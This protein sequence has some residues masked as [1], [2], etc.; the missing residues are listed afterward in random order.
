MPSI[1]K[2]KTVNL[3]HYTSI[4][5]AVLLTCFQSAS[6]GDV[7]DFESLQQ[8]M[9][10]INRNATNSS[11]SPTDTAQYIKQDGNV[12]VIQF[13]GNYDQESANGDF[14]V[15]A[16][17]D[18]AQAFYQQHGDDY[19][20]LSILTDFEFATGDAL[21]F[22]HSTQNKVSGIGLP[23]FDNTAIYGS[24][25]RLQGM[26]DM[27]AA[28]R[29]Q[30]DSQA[31]DFVNPQT[32]YGFAP[33][34]S[35]EIM[36]NWM[37]GVDIQN[38][39]G[40]LNQALRGHA[41][42]HWSFLTDSKASVMGGAQWLS[43][44]E[45][46]H[47]ATLLNQTYHDWDLYLAGLLDADSTANIEVI[48]DPSA[49]NTLFP[50][51]NF[52]AHGPRHA[53]SIQQLID[54]YGP[55][56]PAS[57]SSQRQF[58]VGFIYLVRDQEHI[59]TEVVSQI[60]ALQQH[61]SNYFHLITRQQASLTTHLSNKQTAGIGQIS[62][63]INP[64][65]QTQ[66]FDAQLA[67]DWLIS[68]QHEDGSWQ[69]KNS[70]QV[71]DTALSTRLIR[72]LRPQ[73]SAWLRGR[74]WL[75]NHQYRSNDERLWALNSG[76]L[77]LGTARAIGGYIQ[78]TQNQDGGWGLD[79]QY[80]S[81]ALDTALVLNTAN[82][83]SGLDL[84]QQQLSDGLLY[85]SST[86]SEQ[87][88][89][90][91]QHNGASSLLSS[92]QVYRT[93]NQPPHSDDSGTLPSSA[94]LLSYLL[95]QQAADGSFGSA[96]DTAMAVESLVSTTSNEEEVT[97]AVNQATAQAI[98]QLSISQD[99]EGHW[100]HSIYATAL[101]S[102]LLSE[103]Q[104]INLSLD[105]IQFS[106][107]RI[108]PGDQFVLSMNIRNSGGQSSQ[109]VLLSLL[110]N[111]ESANEVAPA[112][113]IPPLMPGQRF[114]V[115]FHL[116]STQIDLSKS[117][118][119]VIDLANTQQELSR[120]DNRK[121]IEF[122][123]QTA[124][125]G[126]DFSI[127]SS[128][129]TLSPD[130]I[131]QLPEDVTINAFISNLGT[132]N[133]GPSIAAIYAIQEAGAPIL[134][135]RETIS[136]DAGQR[137]QLSTQHSFVDRNIIA[138]QF[139]V[140]EQNRV[141]ENNEDNN[142]FTL[143]IAYED[144]LDFTAETLTLNASDLSIGN[145]YPINFQIAN[146][147][148]IDAQ[149][150]TVNLYV[151]H[152]Q[153]E[154]NIF[155]GLFDIT[156][157]QGI[158]HSTDWRPTATG[159]HTLTLRVDDTEQ[160]AESEEANNELS[161][162]AIV[163]EATLPNL[164]LIPGISSTP[165][166]LL[167]GQEALFSVIV[168]ND[169]ANISSSVDVT[170][171]QGD[172][173]SSPALASAQITEG[174][175]SGQQRVVDIPYTPTGSGEQFFAAKVDA[176]QRIS[177]LDEIDNTTLNNLQV[178]GLA[179]LQITPSAIN[180]NPSNPNA[181][182]DV[183]INIQFTNSGQ[184]TT[185]A[186]SVV[187]TLLQDGNRFLEQRFSID[188][189]IAAGDNGTLN[190]QLL[191][192]AG[193]DELSLK[194]IL[195]SDQAIAESD[196]S[197]NQAQLSISTQSGPIHVTEQYLSP[198]GDE[199]KDNTTISF[200]VSEVA[201][202]RLLIKGVDDE[203]VKRYE[204]IP[205]GQQGSVIWD[206]RN[207]QGRI[208]LDGTYSVQLLRGNSLIATRNIVVDTDRTALA[209]SI[210]TPRQQMIPLSCDIGRPISSSVSRFSSRVSESGE[211]LYFVNPTRQSDDQ[212]LP[213]IY[214]VNTQSQEVTSIID[215]HW[216]LTLTAQRGTQQVINNAYPL[217][218]HR[219]LFEAN[220]SQSPPTGVCN[221][222][223]ASL[224]T[225]NLAGQ[226]RQLN[227]ESSFL[228]QVIDR[229][230]DQHILVYD[231]ETLRPISLGG[232]FYLVSLDGINPAKQLTKPFTTSN[233]NQ[234]LYY[235][236]SGRH[237]SVFT[238]QSDLNAAADPVEN[239][240]L[241]LL[242]L[243]TEGSAQLIDDIALNRIALSNQ[244][245][246]ALLH[247]DK[248]ISITDLNSPDAERIY[249]DISHFNSINI[250]MQWR[251]SFNH[252]MVFDRNGSQW[253][254][255]NQ[256]GQLIESHHV[257]L[258]PLEQLQAQFRT[259]LGGFP[260]CD[261][262]PT[263]DW[264]AR[265]RLRVNP[266]GASRFSLSGHAFLQ[267]FITFSPSG[268]EAWWQITAI[269]EDKDSNGEV[270]EPKHINRVAYYHNFNTN[271]TH[272][273]G[274]IPTA[275]NDQDWDGEEQIPLIDIDRTINIPITQSHQGP[276]EWLLPGRNLVNRNGHFIQIR[277]HPGQTAYG[278]L[279]SE[280]NTIASSFQLNSI[281]Y[282]LP[283]NPNVTT[284]QVIVGAHS[285][286]ENA[287][288]N[289]RSGLWSLRSLDNLIAQV[290]Y[291][292]DGDLLNIQATATDKNFSHY[293][294]D[295][296]HLDQQ[297][298]GEPNIYRPIIAFADTEANAETISFWSPPQAGRYRIRLTVYDRAGNQAS[299]SADVFWS[300]NPDLT[301][302]DGKPNYI[303]PNAD[304][305]NDHFVISYRAQRSL[306]L[307]VQIYDSSD[308][309]VRSIRQD[310][311]NPTGNLEQVLWDGRDQSGALV[312]DG[313]YSVRVNGHSLGVVV[314]QHAPQISDID[315]HIS[316][317]S[318]N[319]VH[320]QPIWFVNEASPA[321]STLEVF[322]GEPGQ[323]LLLDS[324][325]LRSSDSTENP[326]H[327]RTNFDSFPLEILAHNPLRL[328]IEDEAGN[329]TS[330]IGQYEP[331]V[332]LLGSTHQGLENPSPNNAFGL[333]ETLFITDR[334]R[335]FDRPNSPQTGLYFT[336]T[337]GSTLA[338]IRLEF[339]ESTGDGPWLPLPIIEDARSEPEAG[340]WS[341]LYPDND[342]R[343][344]LS[345]A[346]ILW[347]MQNYPELSDYR[348][349][350]VLSDNDGHE[351][352]SNTVLFNQQFEINTIA[353]RPNTPWADMLLNEAQANLSPPLDT[354]QR[355]WFSGTSYEGISASN[356]LLSISSFDDPR[357]TQAIQ[358]TPSAVAEE[359][360]G[361]EIRFVAIFDA[362]LV[363]PFLYQINANADTVSV[364]GQASTVML[365]LSLP[366]VCGPRLNLSIS[367]QLASECDVPISPHIIVDTEILMGDVQSLVYSLANPITGENQ[368]I[369]SDTTVSSVN[370]KLLDVS[371]LNLGSYQLTVTAQL[372]DNTEVSAS[373][374]FLV[375]DPAPSADIHYPA[376]GDTI[377]ANFIDSIPAQLSFEVEASLPQE[378]GL[379]HRVGVH[380]LNSAIAI[381]GDNLEAFVGHR[382]PQIGPAESCDPL[383][384][385]GQ[386]N[387]RFLPES[388]HSPTLFNRTVERR[389]ASFTAQQAA[390]AVVV[391]SNWNGQLSCSINS[392]NLD[393][394]I[395]IVSS[396]GSDQV[397]SPNNDGVLDRF[398]IDLSVN[399]VVR[400][401]ITIYPASQTPGQAI[402]IAGP[403]LAQPI[404]ALE[405]NGEY[406]FE[407]DGSSE[408]GTVA[409]GLYLVVVSLQD[410]CGFETDI[411]MPAEVDTTPPDVSISNPAD[412]SA[413][414]HIVEVFGSATDPNFSEY[415]LSFQLVN[416]ESSSRIEVANNTV[417]NTLLG[418]WN[419]SGISEAVDLILD[420]SDSAGN[421]SSTRVRLL[422]SPGNSL[423]SD[424]AITPD[425]FSPDVNNVRDFLNIAVTT[426]TDVLLTLEIINP[427]GQ[428]IHLLSAQHSIDVGTHNYQWDGRNA[429]G[430][431][432]IDGHYLI[433]ASAQSGASL[434][435]QSL[436]FQL[437]NSAPDIQLIYP[438]T[439]I[440][441]A[442]RVLSL[443]INDASPTSLNAELST[444][445]RI[446]QRVTVNA[447][448][449]QQEH[450]INLVEL[451]ELSEG[452]YELT[453]Q[454][455]DEAG[456]QTQS[457]STFL[458]DA[459]LPVSQLL[460]P[461]NDQFWASQQTPLVIN[462]TISDQ[463]LSTYRI[464]YRPLQGAW[465]PIHSAVVDINNQQ[466]AIEF[467][468]HAT[469]R[470]LND[471]D[472]E[473][474]LL[475]IDKAGNE[476]RSS[477]VIHI[478]NTAPNIN[479][480]N[481]DENARVAPGQTLEGSVHDLNL[482][483]YVVSLRPVTTNSNQPWSDFFSGSTNHSGILASIPNITG[484]TSNSAFDIRVRAT[485]QAANTQEIVR[486]IVLD[487]QAPEAPENLAF[488]QSGSGQIQ[489]NW[490]AVNAPDLAAY[491]MTRNGQDFGEPTPQNQINFTQL[492]DGTHQFQ[493][494]AFDHSGN[495][496]PL[497]NSVTVTIDTQAPVALIHAPSTQTLVSGVLDINASVYGDDDLANYH[498]SIINSNIVEQLRQSSI[499]VQSEVIANLNSRE[500]PDGAYTLTL[501]A[502]DRAENTADDFVVIN[503]DNTAPAA[504]ELMSANAVNQQVQLSWSSNTE[505]DL[506]GY[507]VYRNGR[508]VSSPFGAANPASIAIDENQYLD[509]NVPDGQHEYQVRAVD[510]AGNL[511][512]ASN[513]LTV[514]IDQKAPTVTWRSPLDQ[515]EFDFELTLE[516][517]S[518]DEDIE[519]VEFSYREHGTTLWNPLGTAEEQ[520]YRSRLDPTL[521]TF[522]RYELR[523]LA[524]DLSG[525]IDNDP[526][527]ISV[528]HRDLTPPSAVTQLTAQVIEDQIRLE[529]V[530]PTD[531]DLLGFFIERNDG[532]G[533]FRLNA[534]AQHESTYL[535]SALADGAYSYQII[536]VD[537]EQNESTPQSIPALVFTPELLGVP[538]ISVNRDIDVELRSPHP[539]LATLRVIPEGTQ[540]TH[541]LAAEQNVVFEA[542]NLS[543]GENRLELQVQYGENHLSKISVQSIQQVA[544][545]SI[546]NGLMADLRNNSVQLSW[547]ANPED[548]I[549]G[550]RLFQASQAVLPT[551]ETAIQSAIANIN[552]DQAVLSFDANLSSFWP[553]SANQ[554]QG[555][556]AAIIFE[557]AEPILLNQVTLTWG[558]F[559][560]LFPPR[561]FRIQA[562]NQDRWFDIAKQE[563][564][565]GFSDAVTFSS[566]PI[567]NRLRLIIEG[568]AP[569]R[570]EVH[571]SE[572]SVLSTPL[573]TDTTHQLQL[574]RNRYQFQLSAVNSF[575]LQ[576]LRTE[577]LSV[578]VGDF[579]SPQTVE[580]V[581]HNEGHDAVLNWTPNLASDFESYRIYRNGALLLSIQDQNIT[582]YRDITLSN[583]VYSYQMSVTD[584]SGNESPRSNEVVLEINESLPQ[585]PTELSLSALP[586]L[587]AFDLSWNASL[588]E[589]IS[590][591]RVGRSTHAEGPFLP[592]Q[593]VNALAYRD[594]SITPEIHYY[595]VVQS[596]DTQGNL[597]PPSNVVN[598]FL[599]DQQAPGTPRI[600]SPVSDGENLSTDKRFI[601]ITGTAEPG[602]LIE[603]THNSELSQTT[604]TSLE[605]QLFQR[606]Y[607]GFVHGQALFSPDG[608]WLVEDNFPN[609]RLINLNN[610]T[611][612]SLESSFAYGHWSEDSQ[613]FYYRND[614]FRTVHQI[615]VRSQEDH[616][617]LSQ[618]S[619]FAFA[620][621]PDQQSILIAGERLI[622][623]AIESGL[624][625]QHLSSGEISDQLLGFSIFDIASNS[626]SWS[627]DSSHF[628][629]VAQGNGAQR[630]LHEIGQSTQ[631]L[632]HNAS[633]EAARWSND[634]KALIYSGFDEEFNQQIFHYER[635]QQINTA[636][637]S[638]VAS[639]HSPVW[640]HDQQSVLW[641]EDHSTLAQYTLL[642]Q[643]IEFISNEDLFFDR[644]QRLANGHIRTAGN[645]SIFDVVTAGQFTFEFLSL[646]SGRN[647]FSTRAIDSAGNGS[648]PSLPIEIDFQPSGETDLSWRLEDSFAVPSTLFVEEAIAIT[649]SALSSDYRG[650]HF[651]AHFTIVNEDRGVIIAPQN[652]RFEITPNQEGS[653]R[654]V[655]IVAPS[656][657][658]RYQLI[659]QLDP[660]N[661]I[662]EVDESNN[663]FQQTIIVL[664]N[665]PP[666]ID[667]QV[668]AQRALAG[669]EIDLRIAL[670]NPGQNFLGR[671]QL[672]VFDRTNQVVATL[673][674]RETGPIAQ[675][676]TVNFDTQWNTVGLFASDYS[677]TAQLLDRHGT[678]VSTDNIDIELIDIQSFALRLDIG[679]GQYEQNQLH[680]LF[681]SVEYLSGQTPLA[682][683]VLEYRITDTENN[684]F[685]QRSAQLGL[686]LPGSMN[687]HQI[688]WMAIGIPQGQYVLEL[689][690]RHQGQTLAS[691]SQFITVVSEPDQ[692]RVI[693]SLEVNSGIQIH[694]AN[695]ELHWQL[696]NVGNVADTGL[697]RISLLN[698]VNTEATVYQEVISL[699]PG[700]SVNNPYQL[701]TT[702][703]ALGSHTL[704][705][706]W[707]SEL[708][709]EQLVDNQAFELID[710]TPPLIEV[711]SP[712]NISPANTL[713][714]LHVQD[715]LSAVSTVELL[716]SDGQGNQRTFT[717]NGPD[718]EQ[719]YTTFSQL[720]EG[721]YQFHA[722]A[723][724]S[725]GNIALAMGSFVVDTTAPIITISG[726]ESSQ[727]SSMPLTPVI[728]VEDIH[729]ESVSI[730][731]NN[732]PYSSGTEIT[733]QGIYQ[734]EVIAVDFAGNRSEHSIEFTINSAQ[735]PPG[736]VN[737]QLRGIGEAIIPR[738]YLI[739]S[740]I[741]N[742]GAVALNN[743]NIRYRVSDTSNNLIAE[744]IQSLSLTVGDTRNEFIW[745]N[746]ELLNIETYQLSAEVQLN[747]GNWLIVSNLTINTQADDF[748]F[749]E[750]SLETEIRASG[751][752]ESTAIPLS[753]DKRQTR[754]L[755]IVNKP[756]PAHSQPYPASGLK[757]QADEIVGSTH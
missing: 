615:D 482:Q 598:G 701:D 66:T 415:Q 570:G 381:D 460:Q 207:E 528:L 412:G 427:Q 649:L 303:S 565:Q 7:I 434:Q 272:I 202:Y 167:S 509:E 262:N 338:S 663:R 248:R 189:P 214:A 633:T 345:H 260:D 493:V 41:D 51:L 661:I 71:R 745:L 269:N 695:T 298:N 410:D 713:F 73:S 57:T 237:F 344:W 719:R 132:E 313:H 245:L 692:R 433:L 83:S 653:V 420:A 286:G 288:S 226:A 209:N 173:A 32:G 305:V 383:I 93:F 380:T 362:S 1:Q 603:L 497:S 60:N 175:S 382:F 352:Y 82:L 219:L 445:N 595:Y 153:I 559:F 107:E 104:L 667:I 756:S 230:D 697:I 256:Q 613:T 54:L 348:I 526:P 655:T 236:G 21:A 152:N 738:P 294:L 666:Q 356:L 602:T 115:E 577:P 232:N 370:S 322:L 688:G 335:S 224:W 642:N 439:P 578:A 644:L 55:R 741:N 165:A 69:D 28:T 549:A 136:V 86:L 718:D 512:T 708:G 432:V 634:S 18:I 33:V 590:A 157:G 103:R 181:G 252:L 109:S 159:Q 518:D 3:T 378:P 553:V 164:R 98:S 308:L 357:F 169:G 672:Q 79:Q 75:Q 443:S 588:S 102:R 436:S 419:V 70:T 47:R 179:D 514:N 524:T 293:R 566:A 9:K 315:L 576:S 735:T 739:N 616:V 668:E 490:T 171:F 705:L 496:S 239:A 418:R 748:I 413:I 728:Q 486:T 517:A 673:I 651:E 720:V 522:G 753:I 619:V 550:Y 228:T 681:S 372:A 746:T 126:I 363:C 38:A 687:Q 200:F 4:I 197:N 50:T 361:N 36:H 64:S 117:V 742:T 474:A 227:F 457:L 49:P 374:R 540:F 343:F 724:D 537:Q 712:S 632:H 301:A 498:L 223:C 744:H 225:T 134:L 247:D 645:G 716:L 426:A 297:N 234:H 185:A 133:S 519:R 404:S 287:C 431:T 310:V 740:V 26:I 337:L 538:L 484:S 35:H 542:V 350:L 120:A 349:R 532:E 703:L 367:P 711:Q 160:Y 95:D 384:A 186:F 707:D 690:L 626:L 96:S 319:P 620:I 568:E 346:V 264:H 333:Q 453:I 548:N 552:N 150:L 386:N 749:F 204:D 680:Q 543:P 736:S 254:L 561:A 235:I 589:N 585:A 371:T 20:F 656:E 397:F 654:E 80:L 137:T 401:D 261:D 365:P 389:A 689:N 184:Q 218:N 700:E 253:N 22:F 216:L 726:V 531:E 593:E 366:V 709:D 425:N 143:P 499:P 99:I 399:E 217:G 16:R 623:G 91:L 411:R 694:G 127:R 665:E 407:W 641:I 300:E 221:D 358:I 717:L 271:Q 574:P 659:A 491:Q 148:T 10:G 259:S 78:S 11:N 289:N 500:F 306:Q 485:D 539:G 737:G 605:A 678:V 138:L 624:W 471:G 391:S 176:E 622:D 56:L 222:R 521:L 706:Y 15:Q 504:P 604:T 231:S 139:V 23:I 647:R 396:S 241:Y 609:S 163:D 353:H 111:T 563:S 639:K 166:P 520:P 479:I 757:H 387:C 456:N 487:N 583:G 621:S 283:A 658:G 340:N 52:E 715:L 400:M 268:K 714:K 442:D 180:L 110:D 421:R 625:V 61:V 279:H 441:S 77:N 177:E 151:R 468:W 451:A 428:L 685:Y 693:G 729:I 170:L 394:G 332:F 636:L 611:R 296:T 188:T 755:N 722:S 27:A 5:F 388:F 657:P 472:Y 201:E 360:L 85:L 156:A 731:L 299:D 650:D 402:Q 135:A 212:A 12:A 199:L 408:L 147:G 187:L 429:S 34:F 317:S 59:N 686:L 190:T 203:V 569:A 607:N 395:D 424:M 674:N 158:N 547:Q 295:W 385:S 750:D 473:I 19:D 398:S 327:R 17:I 601:T 675:A 304:Q 364:D 246:L 312:P 480:T 291:R 599:E 53:I 617:L 162:T 704:F 144:T 119:G 68:Q 733:E 314:D 478:D 76:V 334:T 39:D 546:P 210:A 630:Y 351:Y 274:V 489:L 267:D 533:F 62:T 67:V 192:P 281:E 368:V 42:D 581:A 513:A 330:T 646:Q 551:T 81:S 483:S 640:S 263:L 534:Q 290:S 373:Q 311:I 747:D 379:S 727:V 508:L 530:A 475:S 465:L 84:S 699:A 435:E 614:D 430:T 130:N 13:E 285:D 562:W 754:L 403:A 554:I 516:V 118:V 505:N 292:L 682:E 507:L 591:Y 476:H 734:L 467:V 481:P 154:S 627:P 406:S 347:Q 417:Q 129:I 606:D 140:D 87:S 74:D 506:A 94:Q 743:S 198:N 155:T 229:V 211:Y 710:A 172:P 145:N 660:S 37:S 462:G 92:L 280:L 238:N 510:L 751:E 503:I 329:R 106:P 24:N 121:T 452:D 664:G 488:T 341:F 459:T 449:G 635:Q 31:S 495:R 580:L 25:G 572:F 205:T 6:A 40:S 307:E 612:L 752:Q 461:Q 466:Q 131:S 255:Y 511:S 501:I 208:V 258:D 339:S 44:N 113:T 178:L 723:Q 618:E 161:V 670:F 213:G 702:Q 323:W 437:D 354:Q 557:L 638:G 527:I 141:S 72:L 30:L 48:V 541:P 266:F 464:E 698:A 662:P 215:E 125:E 88:P 393:T 43:I 142:E 669:N 331:S 114:N 628:S 515:T 45:Q 477:R 405:I 251:P 326:Q 392:F 191:W 677:I 448:G 414:S 8:A 355:I 320:D 100:Q 243:Q 555:D 316:P 14:N 573:I 679:D 359:T 544:S 587:P 469:D 582:Q 282:I 2:Q 684:E 629:F 458:L 525:N 112:L 105:S 579:T 691:Q 196:E 123:V 122:P 447:P 529:W 492:S 275:R 325:D 124:V 277:I 302:L 545:P 29:Y 470:L 597:S 575:G 97:Q 321:V 375:Q 377:C 220:A 390:N 440:A 284:N 592:L 502:T 558:S 257:P 567:T 416:S 455:Q 444:Q 643:N 242:P 732:R 600:L 725:A 422:P 564:Q 336:H 128:A 610:G 318:L 58:R 376:I 46:Q 648:F 523:A 206:G 494:L 278:D 463:H 89:V 149:N 586:E 721:P 571:L 193:G 116:D 65:Q 108:I 101:V 342:D 174:L 273:V 168:V 536:A 182:D 195:D 324:T 270:C 63:V 450:S 409:D 556:N 652:I 671:L 423:I 249:I 233:P 730:L 683:A 250:A 596:I 265:D 696:D 183:D 637:T 309:L 631:T 535:D 446:V 244:K 146:R 276:S 240:E 194:V 594:T 369:D 560:S 90:G 438:T 328:T 676:S 454:A 584:L 608:Q